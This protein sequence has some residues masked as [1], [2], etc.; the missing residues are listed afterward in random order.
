M[1]E[2]IKI[3]CC[4]LLNWSTGKNNTMDDDTSSDEGVSMPSPTRTELARKAFKRGDPT[5]SQL[6]HNAKVTREEHKK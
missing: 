2:S 4:F 5:V 6:V 3:Y 1:L